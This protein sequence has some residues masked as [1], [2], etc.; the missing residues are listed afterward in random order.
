MSRGGEG[1][2]ESIEFEEEE[3][4]AVERMEREAREE[5]RAKED[6]EGRMVRAR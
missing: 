6:I 3:E 4:K 1:I 2:I 5:D